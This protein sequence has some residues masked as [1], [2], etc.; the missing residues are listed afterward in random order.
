MTSGIFWLERQHCTSHESL[1]VQDGLLYLGAR[2]A[3]RVL[4]STT[5]HDVWTFYLPSLSDSIVVGPVVIPV[6]V[7]TQ[8]LVVFGTRENVWAVQALVSLP[9]SEYM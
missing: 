5:G 1:F 7:G 4:N 3:L 2:G 9:V 6:G 8:P